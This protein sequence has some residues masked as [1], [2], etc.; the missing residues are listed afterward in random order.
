[1]ATAQPTVSTSDYDEPI[2]DYF[3]RASNDDFQSQTFLYSDALAP[4]QQQQQQQQQQ[5]SSAGVQKSKVSTTKSKPR[6]NKRSGNHSSRF[7][8]CLTIDKSEF[9]LTD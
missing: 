3:P 2:N 5:H 6:K 7:D 9:H 4:P 1:M 8:R